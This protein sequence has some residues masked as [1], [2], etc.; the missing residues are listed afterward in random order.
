[1][2][3]KRL[4]AQQAKRYTDDE[5]VK[6]IREF[7]SSDLLLHD[8]CTIKDH[9]SFQDMKRLLCT[10]GIT[11]N[12]SDS[13][14]LRDTGDITDKH[15][16]EQLNFITSTLSQLHDRLRSTKEEV[17]SLINELH[18]SRPDK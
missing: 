3:T 16:E 2:P 12:S 9:P 11:I 10:S 7:W 5:R 6:L 17:E 1:M 14:S 15:N 8:F 4:A 18:C 13:A